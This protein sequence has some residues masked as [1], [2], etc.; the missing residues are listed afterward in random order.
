MKFPIFYNCL[1]NIH[2][3]K[4]VF[5][6]FAGYPHNLPSSLPPL[7]A[8]VRR[9]YRTSVLC[10]RVN[11]NVAYSSPAIVTWHLHCSPMLRYSAVGKVGSLST[12]QRKGFC[13]APKAPTNFDPHRCGCGGGEQRR[14]LFSHGA[15][16]SRYSGTF[17]LFLLSLSL[18][19]TNANKEFGFLGASQPTSTLVGLTNTN[20]SGCLYNLREMSKSGG[21]LWG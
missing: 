13:S 5:L 17:S 15:S 16:K 9:W 14:F 4:T 3:N 1:T 8:T 19:E 6:F 11:K 7:L 21:D 20:Q 18:S 2:W 12:I 10:G